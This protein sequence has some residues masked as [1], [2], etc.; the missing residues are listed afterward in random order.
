MSSL[1]FAEFAFAELVLD[2]LVLDEFALDEFA[3]DGAALAEAALVERVLLES[4]LV[5]FVLVD[6]AELVRAAV[7][8]LAS[9]LAKPG[10][11]LPGLADR[12]WRPVPRF[13]TRLIMA[14]LT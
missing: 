11:D 2:E 1:V 3:L 9:A 13:R 5:E 4:V 6:P 10:R 12:V 8:V 7:V 14:P